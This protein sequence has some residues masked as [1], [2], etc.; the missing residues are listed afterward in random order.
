MS[1]AVRISLLL[2]L[3]VD[4]APDAGDQDNVQQSSKMRKVGPG[5]LFDF[6]ERLI[7]IS[8][9]ASEMDYKISRKPVGGV[10]PIWCIKVTPEFP[11]GRLECEWDEM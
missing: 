8:E 7:E 5:T 9:P 1:K 2:E 6:L 10:Y 3:E 11:N 4:T